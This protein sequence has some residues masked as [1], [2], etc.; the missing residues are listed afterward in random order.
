MMYAY[1]ENYILPLSHDEV[2]H[3]KRSLLGKMPGS[4]E[5]KFANLRLFY[6]Y[7]LS[8][9]GKKLLFMGGEFG[10]FA[11]WKDAASLDWMLLDYPMHAGLHRFV[12]TLNGLYASRPALWEC[13][14]E[15]RGFQWIDADNAKQSV[16]SFIR[17]RKSGGHVAAVC[18]FSRTDYDRFRIGVPAGSAYRVV[19]NS[20]AAEYGGAGRPMPRRVK[21]DRLKLHGMPFSVELPVP[22]LTFLLLEPIAG[23]GN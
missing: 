22:P 6:G 2:V 1:S 13:D 18:N 8:F 5:E 11:E 23:G 20:D 19:F 3:G 17:R 7:F 12:Q 4:Y 21:A 14:H 10:Q 16:V 9:P 15:P